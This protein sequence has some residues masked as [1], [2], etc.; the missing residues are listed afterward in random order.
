[1]KPDDNS[2]RAVLAGVGSA[3]LAGGGSAVLA[4][5][6]SATRQSMLHRAGT[7][8]ALQVDVWPGGTPKEEFSLARLTVDQEPGQF[9]QVSYID[10]GECDTSDI[11]YGVQ[12]VA[13]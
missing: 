13:A 11:R 5:V 9:L 12:P 6:G 4:G 1:M 8:V 7:V 10:S 3:A 2:L